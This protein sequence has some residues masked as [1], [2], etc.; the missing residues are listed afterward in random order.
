VEGIA[1][2]AVAAEREVRGDG[3]G[4]DLDQGAGRTGKVEV[5]GDF[6]EEGLRELRVGGGWSEELGSEDFEAAAGDGGTRVEAVKMR[7]VGSG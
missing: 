1:G 2:E 6:A 4:G 7:G 5:R 3:A